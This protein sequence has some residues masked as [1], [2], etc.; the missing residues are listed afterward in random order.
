MDNI[1]DRKKLLRPLFFLMLLIFTANS[2]ALAFHWYYSIWWFDMLMHF[3]GGLWEGLFF[4]WFF[5]SPDIGESLRLSPE[6]KNFTRLITKTVLFVLLIGVLWE[7]FE[8]FTNNYIGS[9]PFNIL[10]TV[11][12]IFFDLAG[13][14]FAVLYFFEKTIFSSENKVQ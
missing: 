14:T 7:F 8:F 11:S 4:I 12:D 13:G 5:S 9:D 3:L 2:L 1:I 10:D 6:P